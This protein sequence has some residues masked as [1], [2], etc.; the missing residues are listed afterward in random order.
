L[1]PDS[2][3]VTIYYTQNEDAARAYNEEAIKLYGEYACLNTIK[4]KA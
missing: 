3:C 2:F 1:T 4:E